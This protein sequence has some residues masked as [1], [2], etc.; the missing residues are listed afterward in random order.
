MEKVTYFCPGKNM[1]FYC[2]I[3]NLFFMKKITLFVAALLTAG[4]AVAEVSVTEAWKKTD[5][6]WN[7]G[8][9]CRDMTLANGKLFVIDKGNAKAVAL[10]TAD[11]TEITASTVAHADIN[12]FSIAADTAGN[13][14]ATNSGW[15]MTN[16]IK[17]G[18][19]IG[20]TYASLG[21]TAIA[22]AGRFD[23]VGLF[24]NIASADGGYMAAATTGTADNIAV[25]TMKN[26]AFDNAAAPVLFTDKRGTFKTGADVCTVDANTFWISGQSQIPTQCVMNAEKSAIT[27]T[28][29]DMGETTAPNAGGIAVFT[30]KAK[31]YVVVPNTGLGGG[32]IWDV[33][34]IATPTLVKTLSDLGTT[35]NG[36][37]HVGIEAEVKEDGAY[38]YIWVPNNGVICYK[39]TEGAVNVENVKVAKATVFATAEGLQAEFDG[40]AT[41]EIFS[42]TGKLIQ[43][44]V[45][46]NVFNTALRAGA[47]LVRIN[48]ETYKFV[49]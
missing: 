30:Y 27:L 10:S 48:G 21:N 43:K 45:A 14:F 6:S 19:I 22:G 35:A 31:Q 36:A 8:N 17:G 20:T 5:Y 18:T 42:T 23:Y 32:T 29:M 12:G 38:I 15:G 26:G 39:M 4:A 46:N 47:Y 37:F 25:W 24:G 3:L 34:T 44:S 49:K 40:E 9:N 2:L 28:A 13:M 16:C 11:G 7:T 41:V 1:Y 33:T